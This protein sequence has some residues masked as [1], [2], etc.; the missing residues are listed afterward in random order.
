MSTIQIKP[1]AFTGFY[2]DQRHFDSFCVNQIFGFAHFSVLP[3][4][5]AHHCLL[6]ALQILLH[7]INVL[8]KQE[9]MLL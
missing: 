8:I 2:S 7:Q 4:Q 1:V 5:F 3:I 6:A 9:Q